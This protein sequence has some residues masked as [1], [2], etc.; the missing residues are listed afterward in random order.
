MI[1]AKTKLVALI[2]N[3][4]S[5]SLSPA[6]HNAAFQEL[7]LNFVY[8]AFCV[9]NLEDAIKAMRALNIQGY[10]VTIPHKEKIIPLLDVLDENAKKIGA[11]NTVVNNNGKLI[12]YN[13]DAKAAVLASLQ[14]TSLKEKRIAL[15]GAGGAARA[16]AIAL[17]N[18]K[19]KLTIFNR[20]I[21]KAKTLAQEAGCDF[22]A[23]EN[24]S[25][26][27]F[28]I[29]I[30]ATSIGMFPRTNESPVPKSVLKKGMIVFDIVYNPLE[31]RLLKEA[32]LAGCETIC[33]LEM[34]LLQGAE[35]FSLWTG[36]KA[37][38]EKM[39]AVVEKEL[40]K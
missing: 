19:T 9:E 22:A 5:H 6:M 36:K 31:T 14:K 13:T 37:P 10:S 27:D 1:D 28:D 16:I 20:T 32:K 24:I 39:R 40:K 12:G 2:G 11:V 25:D 38:I 7:K 26:F 35:Q 8:L 3:P 30:N 17:Q 21:E 4:V 18:E 33:G 29:L 23:M 15:V 34:F